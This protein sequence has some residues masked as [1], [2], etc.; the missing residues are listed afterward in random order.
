[1]ADLG[2]FCE[3]INLETTTIAHGICLPWTFSSC[4]WISKTPEL[5][6]VLFHTVSPKLNVCCP[7]VPELLA[8]KLPTW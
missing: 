6:T 4:L 3:Q 7:F 8:W 5:R 2:I 1:M